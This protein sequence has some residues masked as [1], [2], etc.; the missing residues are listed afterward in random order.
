MSNETH[1]RKLLVLRAVIHEYLETA[2]PVSSSAIAEKHGVAASSATIRNDMAELEEDGLLVQPHTSAGRIPTEKGYKLYVQELVERDRRV[3]KFEQGFTARLAEV[4]KEADANARDIAKV[5]SAETGQTVVVSVPSGGVHVAGLAHLVRK[6][7]F[8][9]SEALAGLT[10]V[11]DEMDELLAD[12]FPQLSRDVQVLIGSENPFG[13]ALSSVLM[14]YDLPE[15]SGVIGI[16]GPTRM[17]YDQNIAMLRS[18]T[19]ALMQ[20]RLGS[21]TTVP[22]DDEQP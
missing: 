20:R 7:E 1:N 22:D 19:D 9:E 5:V 21:G 14:R 2:E 4:Q 17:D 6:P 18:L 12:V 13:T 8:R 10:E 15:G 3:A 11:L 16:L